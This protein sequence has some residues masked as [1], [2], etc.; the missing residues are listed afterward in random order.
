MPSKN[1]CHTHAHTDTHTHTH[2]HHAHAHAHGRLPPRLPVPLGGPLLGYTY[3]GEGVCGTSNGKYL[4]EY[5]RYGN[6]TNDQGAYCSGQCAWYG[7]RCAGF[8]Y[9]PSNGYCALSGAAFT[10]QGTPGGGGWFFGSGNGGTGPITQVSGHSGY[11]CYVRNA[12]ATTATTT[13]RGELAP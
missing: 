5:F 2:T 6:P 8:I 7:S 13:Q 1:E 11:Y 4:P 3:Q 10:K 9:R 12:T